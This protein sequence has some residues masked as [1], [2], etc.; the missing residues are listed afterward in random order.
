MSF[1]MVVMAELLGPDIFQRGLTKLPS[2]PVCFIHVNYLPLNV[3]S[4]SRPL[5]VAVISLSNGR[6][7]G[8]AQATSF[9]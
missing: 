4:L 1:K 7:R 9:R 3:F 6:A 8:L 5:M 2:L